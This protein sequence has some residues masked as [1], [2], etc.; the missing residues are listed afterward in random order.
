MLPRD[1][2]C[3]YGPGGFFWRT[4]YSQI[5]PKS[6]K[7]HNRTR[8]SNT[9]CSTPSL[10]SDLSIRK[11]LNPTFL[12]N[13]AIVIFIHKLQNSCTFFLKDATC[14]K[15]LGCPIQHRR[16]STTPCQHR[17]Y[18]VW[19]STTPPCLWWLPLYSWCTPKNKNK[20]SEY[21]SCIAPS[22]ALCIH[23]LFSQ[24]GK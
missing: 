3:C 18:L 17:S 20:K 8:R 6:L 2:F 14:T 19:I 23:L 13:P 24:I 16:T 11:S 22:C 1:I 5:S 21:F 15:G 9:H 4:C 10:K 7:C 12:Y